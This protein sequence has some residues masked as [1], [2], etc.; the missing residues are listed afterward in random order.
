MSIAII[1]GTTTGTVAQTDSRRAV[2]VRRGIPSVPVGGGYYAVSGTGSGV[3]GASAAS[4]TTFFSM[5]FGATPGANRRAYIYS[6]EFMVGAA[7]VGTSGLV[8][9]SLVVNRFSGAIPTGGTARTVCPLG[10]ATE[11]VGAK[12]G[13]DDVSNMTDVRDSQTGLTTTGIVQVTLTGIP[14]VPIMISDNMLAR[15][16]FG[17]GAAPRERRGGRLPYSAPI[18]M[19]PGSGIL[20]RVS[21]DRT[22]PANQTWKFAYNIRWMEM[23]A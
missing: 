16:D 2:L 23:T 19:M 3:V 1:G 15:L 12:W 9:G 17:T 11:G 8:A 20:A 21:G 13:L 7:T 6:M 4:S 5:W 14:F 22:M 18:V 10:G